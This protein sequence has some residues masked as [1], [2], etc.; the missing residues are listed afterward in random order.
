MTVEDC[1]DLCKGHKY[2]GLEYGRECYCGDSLAGA[3]KTEKGAC[4]IACAG[5]KAQTCGG[6][7]LLSLYEVSTTAAPED[8]GVGSGPATYPY[9]RM[10]CYAEPNGA[11]ALSQVYSSTSMT[12][13]VC[14][15]I[16]GQGGYAYAGL[17]YGQECWCGNG[18][19]KNTV[20]S[21][22]MCTEPCKGAPSTET[23]GAGD[24]IE[25]YQL[26]LS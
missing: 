3:F 4:D 20:E 11:K 8:D 13:A 26:A 1:A 6:R 24:H 10:G 25:L 12:H 14:F 7:M 22:G 15:K 9:T 16:C 23:C 5:N 2:Y 19:T 18:I 17:E 21:P